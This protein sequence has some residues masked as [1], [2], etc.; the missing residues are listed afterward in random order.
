MRGISR[1]V[2]KFSR[3]RG[4]NDDSLSG[5][6]N[7][8]QIYANGLIPNSIPPIDLCKNMG[9]QLNVDDFGLKMSIQEYE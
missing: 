7:I 5:P 3:E 9:P 4:I 8:K 6:S 2:I 1:L